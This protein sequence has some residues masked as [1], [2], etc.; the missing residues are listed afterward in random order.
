M[1]IALIAL[2]REKVLRKIECKIAKLVSEQ[3][4][5]KAHRDEIPTPCNCYVI[6]TIYMGI[7]VTFIN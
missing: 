4:Y 1:Y 2:A 5:H 3:L 6:E 7:W